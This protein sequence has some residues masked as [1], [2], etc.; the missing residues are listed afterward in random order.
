KHIGKGV[1]KEL[2]LN[3]MERASEMKLSAVEISSDPNAE[4]FYH[5]LGA[6]RIGETVSEI[7]GQP[8]VLPRLRIDPKSS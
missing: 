2:F 6:K 3:A 7:D 5:R 1:G 8:R 4:D